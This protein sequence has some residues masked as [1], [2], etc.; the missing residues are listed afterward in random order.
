ME[1]IV[2]DFGN[3]YLNLCFLLHVPI[4]LLRPLPPV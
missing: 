4:V 2:T 3:R 1:K